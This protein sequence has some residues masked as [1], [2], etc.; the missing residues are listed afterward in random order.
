MALLQ[1]EI[2][3][4]ADSHAFSPPRDC[5]TLFR[6]YP[7]STCCLTGHAGSMLP[8]K[9]MKV[10]RL[11]IVVVIA[12]VWL[13]PSL[14]LAAASAAVV[15]VDDD[16]LAGGNGTSWV[17][18]YSRLQDALAFAADPNNNV[19]EIRVAQ[20]IARQP[21]TCSMAFTFAVVTSD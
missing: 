17:S 2:D 12:W 8:V 20:A 10:R 1:L 6:E 13:C 4:E 14:V 3:G 19:H 21:F 15:Y 16:A 7:H 9:I 11:A 18:A 5:L